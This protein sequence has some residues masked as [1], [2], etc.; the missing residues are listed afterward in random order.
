MDISSIMVCVVT[1]RGKINNEMI[2]R[3]RTALRYRDIFVTY[4]KDKNH[5][6]TLMNQVPKLIGSHM[7]N[8]CAMINL[9]WLERTK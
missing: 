2:R 9:P 8:M 7:Q 1:T 3:F 5:K 6:M 4:A